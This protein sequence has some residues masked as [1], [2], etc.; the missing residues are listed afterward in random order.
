MKYFHFSLEVGESLSFFVFFFGLF[1]HFDYTRNMT[2]S[3]S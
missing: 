1:V 2:S 3:V